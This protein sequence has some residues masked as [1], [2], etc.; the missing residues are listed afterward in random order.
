MTIKPQAQTPSNEDQLDIIRHATEEEIEQ[1]KDR[2]D[3]T[4]ATS[5][6][7]FGGKD[8]AV[9]RLAPELDPVIFAP[10]TTDK[11][12]LLFLMNLETTLRLQ[13]VKEIYFNIKADDKVT[14]DVMK[15]WGAVEQSPTPE[16]RFKKV[17]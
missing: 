9:Y 3:L 16:I 5:V 13:G 14:H 8:F 1:I 10:D 6:V 7:T 4:N 11:R 17:L 15:H 2:S 12:K